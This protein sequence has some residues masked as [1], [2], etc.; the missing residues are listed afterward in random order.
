MSRG[1]DGFV[2][3]GKGKL[4]DG[5]LD[6]GDL[7]WIDHEGFVHLT[8]RAKDLIIRG[9]HNIDPAMIEDALLAH[10]DVTGAAAVGRP[11]EHAGEVPVAYVTVVAGAPAT[12][13]ELQAWAG[14]HVGERP[15][16]PKSVTIIDAIPV[17]AVGKPYKPPLR[18]DAARIAIQDALAKFGG[19]EHVEAAVDDSSIVVTITVGPSANQYAV[20][21]ELDRYTVRWRMLSSDGGRVVGRRSGL[22]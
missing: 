18:A 1:S 5:W 12:A 11:D 3:D 2:L 4:V 20:L 17:T 10:P 13:Q 14:Q 22:G 15:A 7:A 19:V 9:G 16:A 8:G 6:T 21:A